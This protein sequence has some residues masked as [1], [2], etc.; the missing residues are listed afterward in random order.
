MDIGTFIKQPQGYTAFVP[1][2]FPPKNLPT[3]DEDLQ[4][5]HDRAFFSLGKLDGITQVLPDL[6][7]FIF[8]YVR[9]EAA[10][11]A[12]IEGTMATMADSIKVDADVEGDIPKDVENISKY[13]QAMNEGL[14][15]LSDLPLS[16]RLIKE[17]HKT[18]MEG[19]EDGKGKTPGRFRTSQNW[20]G[21]NSP[22]TAKFVPPPAD[23]IG[24]AMSDLEEFLHADDV[25]SPL[26]KTALAHAQFE[27]IHPF[28]DGNGRVGRLLVTFYLCQLELLDKPVLYLSAYLR[29]HREGYF[30]LI[31]RY[32]ND[33]DFVSWLRF[34]LRGI[35]EV[36]EDAIKTARTIHEIRKEDL[37][38]A[39]SLG[40][41]AD[42]ATTVLNKL[43]ELPIVS[44]KKVESW[45]G[46]SRTTANELVDVLV[47]IGI[48]EQQDKDKN[49]D[50]RFEYKRY[51]K[52]FSE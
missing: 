10:Y 44:V 42:N 13:I 11:S 51:L 3:L 17:I 37:E 20:I 18:L 16:S 4:S 45:T 2:K 34:F 28:L 21:G 14:G 52:A 24:D 47:D 25:T 49:Y 12:E 33:G 48:L 46:L 32:H 6:D 40:R 1:K 19:T 38:K 31:N 30:D 8:M 22:D 50:R 9:K 7:F 41:R 27:T 35:A 43:Y 26:V 15:K 36:S 5:L 23:H 39:E 29:K